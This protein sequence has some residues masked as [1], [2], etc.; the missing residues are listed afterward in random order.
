MNRYISKTYIHKQILQILGHICIYLYAPQQQTQFFTAAEHQL[1][2]SSS[3]N[4]L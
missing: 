1:A 2:L 4:E 3:L